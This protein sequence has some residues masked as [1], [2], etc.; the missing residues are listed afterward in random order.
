M[1]KEWFSTGKLSAAAKIQHIL[2]LVASQYGGGG[3]VTKH[4]K[5]RGSSAYNQQIRDSCK[6]ETSHTYIYIYIMMLVV[7]ASHVLRALFLHMQLNDILTHTV[8][9]SAGHR[10]RTG[11]NQPRVKPLTGVYPSLIL[12][13][14]QSNHGCSPPPTTYALSTICEYFASSQSSI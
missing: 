3:F 5:L 2:N 10:C 4:I 12:L 8:L 1:N 6:N 9:H 7:F 13:L 11:K 14:S